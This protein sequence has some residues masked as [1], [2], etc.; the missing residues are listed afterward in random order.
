M[1]IF[2]NQKIIAG[3]RIVR[4]AS[5]MTLINV[6]YVIQALQ[7]TKMAFAKQIHAQLE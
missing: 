6:Q 5:V 4:H 3:L 1:G 2:A 7:Q